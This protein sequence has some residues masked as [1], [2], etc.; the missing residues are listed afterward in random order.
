MSF[1]F[2]LLG[3]AI[4]AVWAPHVALGPRF[5]VQPWVPLFAAATISGLVSGVLT[6]QAL[7]PLV[8]LFAASALSQRVDNRL[9]RATLTATA[10]VLALAL[11]LH[12]L[13]GFNNPFVVDG[14]RLSETAAPF[15][16][17]ANFDKGAAGLI[18]LAFFCR[19]VTSFEGWRRIAVPTAIAI[20]LTA[21]AVIVYALAADYVRFDPKLPTFA[22]AFLTVNLLF[23]CVAEEAFFRGLIQER[24][25]QAVAGPWKWVAIAVS[26]LLFGLAHFAGGVEYVVLACI[27]GAG[28]AI[29][30]A[31][32]QR[33]EAAVLTHFG[34][35]AIH[36]F[37]FTYPHLAR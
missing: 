22:I 5:N 18:L 12:R 8:L 10:A 9:I 15:T 17:Y 26:A 4:C 3:I 14:V 6:W 30:Y 36:F 21:L 27:A 29:V 23:T 33:I 25:A 11:A 13:P 7:M 35:N 1:T 2:V 20:V 37:G 31:H 16:Q 28:Y 32:T 19:R 34:V 24:L